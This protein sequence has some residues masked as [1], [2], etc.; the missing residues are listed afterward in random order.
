MKSTQKGFVIPVI[1]VLVILVVAGAYILGKGQLNKQSTTQNQGVTTSNQDVNGVQPVNTVSNSIISSVRTLSDKQISDVA[2]TGMDVGK[3]GV[4]DPNID[5]SIQ[6]IIRGD[7]NGDGSED[8]VV[9]LR[10][11]GAS[12]GNGIRVIINNDGI[13][14]SITNFITGLPMGT[15]LA[16]PVVVD[17]VINNGVIKVVNTDISM[18]KSYTAYFKFGGG[19]LIDVTSFQTQT[20]NSVEYIKVIQNNANQATFIFSNS[21]RKQ[22]IIGPNIRYCVLDLNASAQTNGSKPECKETTIANDFSLQYNES[23]R[24][25]IISYL[26]LGEFG[27]SNGAFRIG[28]AS[29]MSAVEFSNI[30]TLNG[31][32]LPKKMVNVY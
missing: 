29:C 21:V 10:H 30:Y 9:I 14:K 12:C 13:A 16:K 3:N 7:L 17:V 6:K 19:T 5:V 26:K 4:K 23:T 22:N 8:A 20:N 18:T 11:C 31:Q 27:A 32:L 25:L 15:T 28:C 2:L 24:T 1:I